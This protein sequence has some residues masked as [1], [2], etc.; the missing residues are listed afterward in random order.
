MPTNYKICFLGDTQVGKTTFLAALY[1]T[2]TQQLHFEVPFDD[3]LLTGEALETYAQSITCGIPTPSTS[4]VRSFR[5]HLVW[6]RR[7]TIPIEFIDIPG[8]LFQ[9]GYAQS[10]GPMLEQIRP[11]VNQC[12]YLYFFFDHYLLEKNAELFD[13]LIRLLR[14]Y[15]QQ[16]QKKPLLCLVLTK[17]D[18]VPHYSGSDGIL[19]L[20]RYLKHELGNELEI[21]RNYATIHLSSITSYGKAQGEL[22]LSQDVFDDLFAPLR[23]LE[24]SRRRRRWLYSF[25]GVLALAGSAAWLAM[26]F[27][28]SELDMVHELG[29]SQTG[30]H[31]SYENKEIY[32]KNQLLLLR[33]EHLSDK[34]I[35][36]IRKR[37]DTLIA[38]QPDFR[39]R[40]EEQ[41]LQCVTPYRESLEKRLHNA[42]AQLRSQPAQD[43]WRDYTHLASL[44]RIHLKSELPSKLHVNYDQIFGTVKI[45]AILAHNYRGNPHDY[46]RSRVQS[47]R[48]YLNSH[49]QNL[50]AK[51][52]LDLKRALALATDF[53]NDRRYHVE[54][55]AK[56]LSSTYDLYFQLQ[57]GNDQNPQFSVPSELY[58]DSTSA[59]STRMSF[60]WNIAHRVKVTLIH[61]T[62]FLGDDDDLL[63]DIW[64]DSN[65]SHVA[66]S[67]FADKDW[68]K[69]SYA[70]EDDAKDVSFRFKLYD[71]EGKELTN[72]DFELVVRY[73][74]SNS[75]WEQQR[76]SL[77]EQA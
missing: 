67:L 1:R 13:S 11:F 9:Q 51:Q 42:I 63:A 33:D 44:Y 40:I 73:I 17:V 54:M 19:K 21:M 16:T 56:G 58:N 76:R 47:I 15:E 53:L 30:W 48:D 69:C 39:T 34:R 70:F 24:R 10:N 38:Q 29:L 60:R 18:Q 26:L 45:D 72:Q 75:F 55:E 6:G 2:N 57:I 74:L 12:D 61:R 23:E 27:Y 8:E 3:S 46:T 49:P 71:E 43:T 52:K 68:E 77:Q 35:A 20:S 64:R 31:E 50:S 62:F 22:G 41:W 14:D 4:S 5:G 59:R 65:M 66:L 32:V 28:K 7:D 37:Y 36:Q 25:L